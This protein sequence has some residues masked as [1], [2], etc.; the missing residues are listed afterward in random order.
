[1]AEAAAQACHA[2]IELLGEYLTMLA[3]AAVHGR[4]PGTSQLAAVRDLGWHAA[5]QGVG[6]GQ[7]VELYLSAAWRL[8]RELPAVVRSRDREQVRA[9]AEAVLRVVD[10]AVGV[11]VDGHQAARRQ[12]IRHEESL[13]REFIDDLLRGDANVSRLVE[14]AEPFGLDLGRPHQVALAAPGQSPDDV[15]RAAIV[16]ERSIVEHFG[17]REVLV[18]TKDGMVVVLVPGFSDSSTR[19]RVDVTTIMQTELARLKSGQPWRLAAGRA[20]VGA[21]GIAR[22]YEE[23]REAL[24]LAVRLGAEAGIIQP[25]DLLVYRVLARDQAATADL[26]RDVLDPLTGARGGP[27]LLLET[28]RCYFSAGAVA[29]ET[30]RRMNVSVRTI[31]YRL[32]RVKAL[33][34]QDAS[35]PANRFALHVAVEG[36]RLLG[37]P[38]RGLPDA[39]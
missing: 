38:D 11:L 29:T 6:A 34:G 1:M 24:T 3:D 36:A 7:A 37:W 26:I 4:R 17:D 23:A 14:R 20:H 31:T 39:Q 12:M 32:A 33:T 25:R 19:R 15:E 8:W 22:S 9:A 16:L 10:D 30:A 18:A 35:D 13:R 2:P 21:Y 5:E 27:E 28:L